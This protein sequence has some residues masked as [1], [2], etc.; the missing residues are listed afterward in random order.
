MRRLWR[1]EWPTEPEGRAAV[2]CAGLFCNMCSIAQQRF[3]LASIFC[4]WVVRSEG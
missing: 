4:N 3:S 2:C 1:A